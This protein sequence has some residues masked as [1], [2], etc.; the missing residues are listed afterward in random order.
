MASFMVMAA[1]AEGQTVY[2]LPPREVVKLVDAP[3]PPSVSLSP[4]RD[5]IA[6]VD[7]EANPPIDLLA[8]PFHGLAGMRVD[9]ELGSEQ[10]TIRFTSIAVRPLA[11]DK[12]A[13]SP[14]P[15]RRT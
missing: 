14:C 3:P 10:R 7:Y 4:R 13:R 8:R 15:R 2:R 12:V 11:G 9:P 6:L 5:T 1:P